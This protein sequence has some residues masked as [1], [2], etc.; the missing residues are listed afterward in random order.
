MR[1]KNSL[2]KINELDSVRT[3]EW[4]KTLIPSS[5]LVDN[6]P[7]FPRNYHLETDIEGRC[8]NRGR[9]AASRRRVC[10]A[11]LPRRRLAHR[12]DVRPHVASGADK[13]ARAASYEGAGGEPSASV[14][15]D[16]MPDAGGASIPLGAD[17]A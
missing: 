6:S 16:L 15:Q 2:R 17:R 9:L 11:Q 1:R 12:V 5:L 4:A 7:S 3:I 14:G 13:S 8:R 10:E